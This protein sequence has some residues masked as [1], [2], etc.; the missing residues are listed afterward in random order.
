MVTGRAVATNATRPV[1]WAYAD[2][3]A[4]TKDRSNRK[5][6]MGHA[7]E[8]GSF[9]LPLVEP[10][11]YE[12]FVAPQDKPGPMTPAIGSSGPVPFTVTT[13]ISEG[14][15]PLDLGTIEVKLRKQLKVGDV[16]A[17][18]SVTNQD[19]RICNLKDHAGTNVLLVLWYASDYSADRRTLK[20]LQRL[21]EELQ[22]GSRMAWL[23]LYF[24]TDEQAQEWIR[25]AGLDWPQANANSLLRFFQSECDYSSTP[26]L[27]LIG[28]DQKLV[29]RYRGVKELRP[30]LEKL[31]ASIT[32]ASKPPQIT[33]DQEVPL[34]GLVRDGK[35]LY[36]AGRYVEA[37]SKLREALQRDPSNRS[38]VAY[39]D[40]VME[41]QYQ[42]SNMRREN[43]SGNKS[44]DESAKKN[45]KEIANPAV[46][47]SPLYN[48]FF[49]LDVNNLMRALEEFRGPEYDYAIHE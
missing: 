38:A 4:I 49:R 42:R 7:L 35:L 43:K 28:P 9:V 3:H 40:L 31:L 17:P 6:A 20:E 26:D 1:H 27:L 46:K 12:L 10:G 11:D 25:E 16:V 13:N 47:P 21:H 41:T 30:A 14:D 2:V 39:L 23:G 34:E 22:P 29:G 44:D 36:E 32:P 18:F 48:R 24:G 45:E 19:G 8:D 15:T 37:E 5:V 33:I